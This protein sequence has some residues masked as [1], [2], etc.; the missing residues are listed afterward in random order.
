MP[1]SEAKGRACCCR[2]PERSRKTHMLE[3]RLLLKIGKTYGE[4]AEVE[5]FQ[6][7]INLI[8]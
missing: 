4:A 7:L 5:P 6:M 1:P 8:R 2:N 3:A